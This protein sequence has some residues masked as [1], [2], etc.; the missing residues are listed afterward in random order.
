MMHQLMPHFFGDTV[1]FGDR[2]FRSDRHIQFGVQ[3]MAEPARPDVSYFFNSI[4][5]FSGVA[6][7]I[8]HIWLNAIEH[9]CEDGF[10][11][12]PNDLYDCNRDEQTDDRIGERIAEPDADCTEEHG[13]T[14]P[15]VDSGVITI[16]NKR[17]TLNF[18]AN[19]DAE[20]GHRFVA[21]EADD[22]SSHDGPK[23]ANRLRM[24]EPA[25]GFITGD[26]GAER[27]GEHD[28]N[29]GQILHAAVSVSETLAR[30]P[31]RECERNPKRNRGRGIAKIMNR[32]REK[33]NALGEI[34]DND[35]NGRSDE[36]PNERPFDRPD[37]AGR[38]CDGSVNNA[39]RVTV[40]V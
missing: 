23:I 22:R 20:N 13:Q 4:D 24:H 14:C 29:A 6:D 34:N 19:F 32:V 9:A 30:F 10:D 3:T 12:L 16:D 2:Q 37:S 38:S 8:D 27:D 1:G 35:L 17:S 28:G 26:G 39:V 36:Q 25:D 40:A 15:A 21:D 31:A 18:L 7:F 5:A 33:T 11:R